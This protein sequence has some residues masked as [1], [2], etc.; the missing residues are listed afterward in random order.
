MQRQR[1]IGSMKGQISVPDDFD[2]MGKDE[3]LTMFLGEKG[4]LCFSR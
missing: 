2:E 1:F 4:A 3:I